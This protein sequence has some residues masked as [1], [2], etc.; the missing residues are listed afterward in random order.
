MLT[1]VI[2][3]ENNIDTSGKNKQRLELSYDP[4]ISILSIIPKA[5]QH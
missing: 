5:L 2:S 4:G 3:L 1:G